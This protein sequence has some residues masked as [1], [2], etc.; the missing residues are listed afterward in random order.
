MQR[1][2]SLGQT[3]ASPC[4]ATGLTRRDCAQCKMTEPREEVT[5]RDRPEPLQ[6]GAPEPVLGAF[7]TDGAGER[8]LEPVESSARVHTPV[9]CSH[10]VP[11]SA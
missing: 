11:L 2:P 7:P 8:P 3:L 4:R 9:R 6:P 1:L 10:L 5:Q